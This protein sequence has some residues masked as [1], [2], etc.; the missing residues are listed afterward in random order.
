M[1]RVLEREVGTRA[2]C[3]LATVGE[4]ACVLAEQLWCSGL[5]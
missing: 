4:H 2:A 3:V 1:Q 5:N